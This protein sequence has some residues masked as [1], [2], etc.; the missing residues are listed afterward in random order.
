MD[1]CGPIRDG[2]VAYS[3]NGRAKRACDVP[4]KRGERRRQGQPEK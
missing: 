2:F 1:G 3:S 4:L